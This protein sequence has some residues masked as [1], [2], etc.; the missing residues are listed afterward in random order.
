VP[1]RCKRNRRR[2]ERLRLLFYCPYISVCGNLWK[3]SCRLHNE[4]HPADWT[5]PYPRDCHAES[6]PSVLRPL[7]HVT[8]DLDSFPWHLAGQ[9]AHHLEKPEASFEYLQLTTFFRA[10]AAMLALKGKIL[11]HTD[12]H[13]ALSKHQVQVGG[14][15]RKQLLR[16]IRTAMTKHNLG[17]LPECIVHPLDPHHDP[18]QLEKNRTLIHRV[19]QAAEIEYENTLT[20]ISVATELDEEVSRHT[21]GFWVK[22]A[23]MPKATK[24][25]VRVRLHDIGHDVLPCRDTVKRMIQTGLPVEIIAV[26]MQAEFGFAPA[27][28]GISE[29]KEKIS[30]G[31]ERPKVAKIIGDFK[32]ILL[33][34]G[35]KMMLTRKHKRRAFLRAVYQWCTKKKTDTFFWQDILE[36]Y[37]ETFKNPCQR[38]LMISSDRID[39]DLFKGQK[40]EFEE[41]FQILDRTAGHLRLKLQLLISKM[42]CWGLLYAFGST[43]SDFVFDASILIA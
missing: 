31:Q 2:Y 24:V 40:A 6:V 10:R 13:I 42:G 32:A 4:I 3:A 35:R 16:C 11:D 21:V 38:T 12:L 8:H 34:S 29:F 9:L 27:V 25:R 14:I 26:K 30:E 33:P 43:L 17:Q 39:N 37:N 1:P 19:I 36:D 28:G 22:G 15:Y 20:F 5:I 18:N 7:T 41:L 23:E